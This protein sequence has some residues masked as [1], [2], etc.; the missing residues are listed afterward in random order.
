MNNKKNDD[1]GFIPIE[2]FVKNL[3]SSCEHHWKTIGVAITS[4]NARTKRPE[5]STI[6][7]CVKCKDIIIGE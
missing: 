5:F 7:Q 2:Q 3:E 1:Y 4:I 6:A